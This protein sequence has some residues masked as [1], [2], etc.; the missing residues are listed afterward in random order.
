MLYTSRFCKIVYMSILFIRMF[1]DT[2]NKE[3]RDAVYQYPSRL[4][5]R[6]FE[7]ITGNGKWTLIHVIA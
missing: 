6:V 2:W 1:F 5:E 3:I 4:E 7:G